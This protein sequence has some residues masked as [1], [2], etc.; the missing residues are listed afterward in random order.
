M[1]SIIIADDEVGIIDLCKMLIEYPNARIIGEAHNGQELFT[2]IGELHPNTVITDICMPGL[3]GLELIEKSKQTYPDVSFIVMSGYTEFEYAR[4]SLRYG[5][6]DYL[7][8]PLRK[9]E[10]N[11]SL[12]K[13]DKSLTE[14]RAQTALDLTLQ[15][16][17]QESLSALREKYIREVWTSGK[18]F[19]VPKIGDTEILNFAD[20]VMQCLLLHVDSR[21][22]VDSIDMAQISRQASATCDKI[23]RL[24]ENSCEDIQM[25]SD[26]PQGVFVLLY[27]SGTAP[28]RQREFLRSVESGI[29]YGNIQNNFVHVMAAVSQSLPASSGTLP[30]LFR[31]AREAVKWRLEKKQSSVICYDW[32]TEKTLD[33]LPLFEG[34]QEARRIAEAVE[35]LDTDAVKTAILTAW[36]EREISCRLIPGARYRLLE[37]ILSCLSDAFQNLPSWDTP[38]DPATGG[39]YAILSGEN[40]GENIPDRLAQYASGTLCAYQ[41]RLQNRENSMITKVKQYVSQHYAENIPLSQAA[42]LVCLSPTYFSKLFK[43]ETGQGFMEYLQHARIEKAK[44]M[45]KETRIRISD[46][47]QA[48]GYRDLKFFNKIFRKETSVTPSEYRKF[49]S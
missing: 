26:G 39:I 5:V 38:Q 47:A 34:T 19:P 22:S 15:N 46:I 3:T 41:E 6:W 8:K 11:R 12:E 7:L 29:R 32:E 23:H 2:M 9:A 21:L 27:A 10:L 14:R 16:D 43:S 35:K 33:A 17:L 36:S 48:V 37:A 40:A 1:L 24:A 25:L 13:L 42:K 45:L 4:T 20:R 18:A 44:K 49:Y 31:Q 28:M 30:E